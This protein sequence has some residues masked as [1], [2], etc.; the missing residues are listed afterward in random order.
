MSGPSVWDSIIIGA[1]HNGLVAAAYLARAGLRVLVLERRDIVGGA[2]VTEE[3]WPGYKVSTA[4]YLV[5]LLRPE[6]VRDL[7]LEEAGLGLVRRDPAG[8][9]PFLDGSH[10]TVYPDENRMRAE[11]KRFCASTPADCEAYFQFERD[12]QRAAAVVDATS[13]SAP[14]TPAGMLRA[15]EAAGCGELYA[16]FVEGSVRDLMD[17][18]FESDRLKAVLATDGLIGTDG[19]PSTSGT[20]YVLLHHYL[21]MAAGSRGEWAYVR[22]GMGTI[23]R[24]LAQRAHEAGAEILT[25]CD[26]ARCEPKPVATGKS[27]WAVRLADGRAFTGETVLSGVDPF[28]T[29]VNLVSPRF[30]TGRTRETYAIE[31]Y[32]R[33]TGASAKINLA[34]SELPRFTCL[35]D[36]GHGD[37]AGPEHVGTVHLCEGMDALEAAWADAAAGRPSHTPMI[38][39]YIQTSVDPSLAPAGRHILSLFVQYYPYSKPASEPDPDPDAFTDRVIEIV[40]RYAPN[41]PG[42]ILHRQVLTPWRLEQQFGLG[43]GH[44]FHGDL[45]PPHLWSGRPGYGCDGPRTGFDGL[46]LCGSGAHPGGCVSGAPGYNAARAA[47]QDL[48]LAPGV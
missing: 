24:L 14:P 40:G 35:G 43:G 21:G 31:A 4:A 37:T 13:L 18:R 11:L 7:A 9:A 10:L 42:S 46:Y 25:G 33:Q 17:G 32:G 39:M 8:F 44:I 45:L 3:P 19:G 20:A 22:G 34:V 26:V 5:S 12:V 2:C 47:L 15:F 36:A 48:G 16:E 28:N 30:D 27:G 1:G 29:F 6:I 23:T 41:V 38:E